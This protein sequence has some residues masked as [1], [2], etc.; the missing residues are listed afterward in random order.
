MQVAAAV[1]RLVM[2]EMGPEGGKAVGSAGLS[3]AERADT[4]GSVTVA[5]SAP[6]ECSSGED[7]AG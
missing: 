1:R 5:D 7:H 4:A 6:C 2:V 3:D